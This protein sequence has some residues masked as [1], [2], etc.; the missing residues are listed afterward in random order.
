[1]GHRSTRENKDEFKDGEGQAVEKKK[2][3]KKKKKKRLPKNYDPNSAPDP[4]RWLPRNQRS[5]YKKRKNKQMRGRHQ[6]QDSGEPAKPELRKKH[7][8]LLP[9]SNQPKE[10]NR[11]K[12]RKRR[13]E[14]KDKYSFCF[15]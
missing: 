13:E 3:K 15:T 10:N 4:D 2:K 8:L 14:E 9:N 1:M 7:Q 12:E 5:G 11:R 6:G